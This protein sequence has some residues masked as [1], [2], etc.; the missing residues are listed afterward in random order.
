MEGDGGGD[1]KSCQLC[2]PSVH[3]VAVLVFLSVFPFGVKGLV[4]TRLYQFLSTLIYFVK[5][6]TECQRGISHFEYGRI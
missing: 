2:L 1:R 6:P 5:Q 3:F 4:R